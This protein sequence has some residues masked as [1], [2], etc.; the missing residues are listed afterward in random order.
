[1]AT[2]L[3]A[4]WL[5]LVAFTALAGGVIVPL[6]VMRSA[7]ARPLAEAV[8]AARR[9]W[10]AGWL[11]AGAV[12]SALAW[13]AAPA[14][15]EDGHAGGLLAARL[16]LL[17]AMGLAVWGRRETRAW[18]LAPALALLLTQSL[19][20]RSAGLPDWLPHTLNDWFHMTLTALWLGGVALLAFVLIPAVAQTP[21]L[22]GAFSHVVD[23]FSPLAMFCVL[24]LGISG[25]IQA[26]AF[27]RA[28]SDLV[29]TDYGRALSAKLLVSAALIGFGAFHQ[30][31]IAPR[32]R[33]WQLKAG[34]SE[35]A[36]AALRFRISLY[37]EVAVSLTLL[38][39]VA[40]MKSSQ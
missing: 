3:V 34:R 8:A 39:F 6:I 11:I 25:I 16:A 9:R 20:S 23:R 24:G 38:V 31:A 40:A 21:A 13:L 36:S 14:A 33:L 2:H 5:A 27:V 1:M 17:G 26:G 32:L 7:A 10:L 30:Q 22:L 15:F 18:M 37:A 28:L 29:A 19:L 12:A 4:H 35:A